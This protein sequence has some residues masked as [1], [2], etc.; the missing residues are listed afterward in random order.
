MTTTLTIREI[1]DAARS[2]GF[3]ISTDSVSAGQLPPPA[4]P[5]AD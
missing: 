3:T 4:A 1:Y 2:A 5:V